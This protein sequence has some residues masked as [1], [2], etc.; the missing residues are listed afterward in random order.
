MRSS[1]QKEDE[2]LIQRDFDSVA[3]NAQSAE[4]R[5][6]R[7]LAAP[8]G[9]VWRAWTCPE[10]IQRW[11]GPKGFIGEACKVDLRAGG[12][13]DLTLVA[14]DGARYPCR[15]S[16]VEV[17]ELERIV[18]D[19]EAVEGHPCGAG[20]PPHSRVTVTFTEQGQHTLLTHHTR[21]FDAAR[22][23]VAVGAGFRQGW[24]DSFARLTNYLHSNP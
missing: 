14:P 11:W 17:V 20:I 21:F 18:Y 4:L 22:L 5:F 2:C 8:R 9:L 19:G 13:F 16:F 10:H 7:L 15:G 6:S 24:E 1:N 3:M 12:Q 23:A